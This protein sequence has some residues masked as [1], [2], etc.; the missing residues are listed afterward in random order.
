MTQ[1]DSVTNE[2]WCA[3]ED[4]EE[5]SPSEFAKQDPQELLP[6]LST[7]DVKVKSLKKVMSRDVTALLSFY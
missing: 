4:K 5:M 2:G 3:Q 1:V 7:S 6:E